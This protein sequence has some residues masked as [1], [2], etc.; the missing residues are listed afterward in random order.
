MVRIQEYG[1]DKLL[2]TEW[3]H[4]DLYRPLRR[5][6]RII[7]YEGRDSLIKSTFVLD[8]YE[9]VLD[10]KTYSYKGKKRSQTA[11]LASGEAKTYHFDKEGSL[12]RIDFGRGE[13]QAHELRY[14]DQ[15]GNLLRSIEFDAEGQKVWERTWTRPADR[16]VLRMDKRPAKSVKKV[17]RNS[18]YK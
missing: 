15:E 6:H 11:S 13:K 8:D 1:K 7:R 2:H 4:P 18:Y 10:G 3:W 5:M 14:Y 9:Q 12:F 17:Y 16:R